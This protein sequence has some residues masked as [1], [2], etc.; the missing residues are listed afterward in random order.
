MLKKHLQPAIVERAIEE[1]LRQIVA[2]AGGEGS[3][4]VNKVREGHLVACLR[5]QVGERQEFP[6]PLEKF[7]GTDIVLIHELLLNLEIRYKDTSFY[8]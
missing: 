1:P 8:R 2:N 6:Y 4:V 5:F 3:V 7:C